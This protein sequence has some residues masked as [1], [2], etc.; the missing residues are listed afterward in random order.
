MGIDRTLCKG[1]KS[2][3]R[4]H[5]HLRTQ[6]G[7]HWCSG[8]EDGNP[9]RRPNLSPPTLFALKGPSPFRLQDSCNGDHDIHRDLLQQPSL[10]FYQSIGQATEVTREASLSH[11]G[12][13]CR[14]VCRLPF[15]LTCVSA[16]FESLLH[17]AGGS[18][19][20]NGDYASL[21]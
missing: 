11:S 20:V 8:V 6:C 16:I 14:E 2:V 10:R 9:C 5:L 7:N 1:S 15:F 13:T 12:Y 18:K 21:S 19:T 17:G 3:R 4:S